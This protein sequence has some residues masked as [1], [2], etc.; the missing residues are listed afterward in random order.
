MI[1]KEAHIWFKL[2]ETESY[3]SGIS[4]NISSSSSIPEKI[5]SV[6]T[7]LK[8]PNENQVF[9]GLIPTRFYF[10]LMPSVLFMQVF[11]SQSSE[12]PSEETGFHIYT[13]Q[14]PH[15]GSLFSN[16]L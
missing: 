14:D 11:Y 13:S 8:S 15:I 2:Y 7:S 1:S 10:K 4:V 9:K 5:S 3:A 6:F 12:W 16:E